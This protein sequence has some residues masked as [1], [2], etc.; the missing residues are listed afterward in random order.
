MLRALGAKN[1]PATVTS[2]RWITDHMVRIDF[3]CDGILHQAGEKPSAWIRAWFPDLTHPSKMHQRGYTLLDADPA[4]GTFG[5]AFLVHDPAGPASTWARSAEVGDELLMT[6]L[7][8]DG[9]DVATAEDSPRGYLLM[10]DVASWPAFTTLIDAIPVGVPVRVVIEH[11]NDDDRVLPLPTRDGLVVD[12]VRSTPDRRA[13]VDAI[14][15]AD[16]YRGWHTWVTAE[17]KATRLAK[18]RLAQEHAQSKSTMHT[19]A[20]WM[21]GR[22]MGRTAEPESQ[23]V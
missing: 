22:A 21:A 23:R 1:H 8:G 20:Y 10:G 13:L 7:G 19:Q 18:K 3:Q 4:A 16:D 14:D 2:I 5:L 12:W 6:R 9:H 17:S 11:S 15:A